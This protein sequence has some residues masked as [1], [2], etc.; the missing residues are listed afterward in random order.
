M[1]KNSLFFQGRQ[2]GA[3]VRHSRRQPKT[4]KRGAERHLFFKNENALRKGA[5][6]M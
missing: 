5:G 3:R 6:R 4:A 2:K 1:M